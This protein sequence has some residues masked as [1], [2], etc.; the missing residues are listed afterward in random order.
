M[1][2]YFTHPLLLLLLLPLP[3]L[4]WWQSRQRRRAVQFPANSLLAG[5]PAGRSRLARGVGV[6]ARVLALALLVIALAGPRWPDEGSRLPTEGIAIALV[7]D[8][9]YS[10]TDKD[11]PWQGKLISRLDAVKNV[12]KLFVLGGDGPVGQKFTGRGNDLLALVVFAEYPETI[13]PLTLDHAA[14]MQM[15]DKQE[16]KK[17]EWTNIGDGIAWALQGL[18]KSG[19]GKKVLVLLTDGEQTKTGAALKPRQA[20]QLAGNMG[21]P[22]YAI[23]VGVDPAQLKDAKPADI[24]DREQAKKIMQELADISQGRYFHAAD[25]DALLDVCRQ[26]DAFE[27]PQIESFQYRRFY[28]AFAWFALASLVLL[29]GILTLE[30]TVWRRLP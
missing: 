17:Q 3:A 29:T 11:F 26:I 16:A 30:L 1:S 10:M 20:A 18:M 21:I 28:Q 13:C 27:R 23:D 22:I 25:A 14:L 19:T 8:V 2:L 24:Q 4:V 12:F 7:V 9:S 15:L 6:A 5:L